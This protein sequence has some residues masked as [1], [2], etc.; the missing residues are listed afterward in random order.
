LS[1]EY[2][3][4]DLNDESKY[5]LALR[6]ILT[7]NEVPLNVGDDLEK[8]FINSADALTDAD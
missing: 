5:H 1:F 4:L 3:K 2:L 8:N 7:S 6:N